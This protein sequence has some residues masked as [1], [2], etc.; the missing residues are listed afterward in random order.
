[1]HAVVRV[2]RACIAFTIIAHG[3]NRTSRAGYRY[4][5][6]G[7]PRHLEIIFTPKP[8]PPCAQHAA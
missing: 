4:T 5:R 8:T 1:M 2:L 3:I 6:Y 7:L